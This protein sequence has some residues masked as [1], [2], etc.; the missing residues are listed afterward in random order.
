MV[1]LTGESESRVDVHA[2]VD[3]N[4]H[5]AHKIRTASVEIEG[6]MTDIIVQPFSDRILVIATQLQKLGTLVSFGFPPKR[7]APLPVLT[8]KA[9]PPRPS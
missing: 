9:V 2:P 5:I 1:I 6:V 4:E 3:D 8:N 7:T